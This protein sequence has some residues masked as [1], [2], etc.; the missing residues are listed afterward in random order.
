M[1]RALAITTIFASAVLPARAAPAPET[2]PK[3]R[4]AEPAAPTEPADDG[5]RVATFNVLHGLT[6]SEPDYPSAA[7]LAARTLLQAEQIAADGI[8]V[9]GLQEV[10]MI[11]PNEATPSD[12]PA[13][14]A[15]ALAE[16]LAG[17]TGERWWW[18][19]YLANPHFP[20]EPD[21]QEGGGGPVSDLEAQLVSTFTGAPY[22]I[23]KEGLAVISRYEIVD[24]E[25]VHLPG[26]LPAEI[27]LCFVESDPFCALTAVGETRAAI[28]ARIQTPGGSVEI[29]STHLAHDITSASDYSSLVQAEVALSF[30]EAKAAA[31]APD[32]AFFVC[33][34]NS[35][36]EDTVPVTQFIEQRGWSNTL[37]G[38][39][40]DGV[41]TSGSDVIVT[42]DPARA[43]D[44]RLDYVF[45]RAGTC[46]APSTATEALFAGEP[47]AYGTRWLWPSDH[48]GVAANVTACA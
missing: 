41:C 19:W 15:L 21:L 17:E 45:T 48:I 42:D 47:A 14:Q 10:S 44:E 23:F 39:C 1:R 30:A 28:W 24:A 4:V 35:E 26:R 7:T 25:G 43:M 36:P 33:D 27:P 29:T 46:T 2:G 18:C 31:G 34:C 3:C 40:G 16:A 5:L 22:A 13:E 38:G 11:E 12:H 6:N 32:H 37:P 9:L 8:D 20:A